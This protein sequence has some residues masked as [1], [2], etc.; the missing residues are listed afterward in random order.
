MQISDMPSITDW[1][2]AIAG[3]IAVP[4]A[5]AG[6]I[7]LFRKDKEK[8]AQINKL[9]GIVEKIEVQNEIMKEANRLSEEQ[10]DILRNSLLLNKQDDEATKRLLEIEEKKFRLTVKPDFRLATSS[11]D[12]KGFELYFKNLGHLAIIKAI[13]TSHDDLILNTMLDYRVD[14]GMKIPI[15]G[16]SISGRNMNTFPYTFEL[17]YEDQIGTRYKLLFSGQASSGKI[18]KVTEVS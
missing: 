12:T 15:I 13:T 14:P 1:I 18:E 2:Q 17:E 6:F 16:H 7:L 3:L 11:S 8:E 10:V 4:G 9:A 5:I